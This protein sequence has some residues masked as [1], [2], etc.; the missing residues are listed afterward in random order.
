MGS[1]C[2]SYFG[3]CFKKSSE[4]SEVPLDEVVVYSSSS[5]EYI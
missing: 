3:L 5:N 1:Y 4:D 2:V